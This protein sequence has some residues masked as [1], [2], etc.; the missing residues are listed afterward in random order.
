LVIDLTHRVYCYLLS[1]QFFFLFLCVILH[2]ILVVWGPRAPKHYAF[3][4]HL[5]HKKIK[6]FFFFVYCLVTKQYRM[7][8]QKN[9][10]I[11]RESPCV[12]AYAIISLSPKKIDGSG[13]S[14]TW[15]FPLFSL[16]YVSYQLHSVFM[17]WKIKLKYK[18]I[19]LFDCVCVCVSLC[20]YSASMRVTVAA[21]TNRKINEILIS[22]NFYSPTSVEEFLFRRYEKKFFWSITSVASIFLSWP[23]ICF[24]N[25]EFQFY[26][27][28]FSH[29]R[30][31][32][33]S[34]KVWLRFF[35]GLCVDFFLEV[36]SDLFDSVWLN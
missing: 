20:V 18:L 9:M 22:Y 7:H 11:N 29:P 13:T 2:T 30:N 27:S 23:M 4:L 32:F 12:Y 3:L 25:L 34:T 10:K 33:R 15:F 35:L 8:E 6:T 16:I 24:T 28:I 5:S 31:S 17:Q 21:S 36:L 1:F 14:W 26:F 19:R